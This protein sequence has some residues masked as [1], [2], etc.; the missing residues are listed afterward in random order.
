MAKKIFMICGNCKY[1]SVCKTGKSRIIDID[2]NSEVYNDIG[3]FG[4]EQY[5]FLTQPKQITLF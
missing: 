1:L 2:V 5:Y 3:C 4:Y